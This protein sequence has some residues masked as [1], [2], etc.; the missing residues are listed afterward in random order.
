ML[1]GEQVPISMDLLSDREV[2]G[3]VAVET[4]ATKS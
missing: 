4:K 2:D 1:L 3:L